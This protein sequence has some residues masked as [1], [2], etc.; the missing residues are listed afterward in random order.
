MVLASGHL[1]QTLSDALD[2]IVTANPEYRWYTEKGAVNLVRSNNEPTL[3]Y[4][5]IAN[6]KG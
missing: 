2:S 1:V 3:F 4:V 6:F 5:P